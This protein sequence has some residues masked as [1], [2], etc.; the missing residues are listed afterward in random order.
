VH[1]DGKHVT[2]SQL[3]ASLPVRKQPEVK[4]I[5]II[6]KVPKQFRE[7]FVS[8]A[9]PPRDN[10][11]HLEKLRQPPNKYCTVQKHPVDADAL[12]ASLEVVA[13]IFIPIDAERFVPQPRGFGSLRAD[14]PDI[15]TFILQLYAIMVYLI[16]KVRSAEI[17][18]QRDYNE[19]GKPVGPAKPHDVEKNSIAMYWERVPREGQPDKTVQYRLIIHEYGKAG[20]RGLLQELNNLIA[21][22]NKRLTADAK[23]TGL[24]ATRASQPVAVDH[25]S[26]IN[27]AQWTHICQAMNPKSFE[28]N[29]I[30]LWELVMH[31]DSPSN[32]VNCFSSA[33]CCKTAKR[34]GADPAYC[35]PGTYAFD[36]VS[37][38]FIF[39]DG[40]INV[41]RLSPIDF[42]VVSNPL[43]RFC[44][45]SEQPDVRENLA[46]RD[47]FQKKHG[48]ADRE[49]S[50]ALFNRTQSRSAPSA[51]ANDLSALCR[52]IQR[53]D[54][55]LQKEHRLPGS[56][57][58]HELD[59]AYAQARMVKCIDSWIPLLSA[60]NCPTGNCGDA[61][62]KLTEYGEL[63]VQANGS[64][65]M[66]R[67]RAFRNLTRQASHFVADAA[68]LD[69]I[70]TVL[71][72][73]QDILLML[74]SVLHT[75]SYYKMNLNH[76]LLGPAGIGKSFGILILAMLMIPGTYIKATYMTPKAFAVPGK[77]NLMMV[78][79]FEDAAASM[80]EKA[81]KSGTSNDFLNIHKQI[82][83]S[84]EITVPTIIMDPK[85]SADTVKGA[86]CV[87]WISAMNNSSGT[88][89]F[90]VKDRYVVSNS[91]QDNDTS[92]SAAAAMMA[93]TQR[94][95]DPAVQ[96]CVEN[97][98]TVFRR[99]QRVIA[100]IEQAEAAG[101]L[102]PVD[103]AASDYF[104][105]VLDEICSKHGLNLMARKRHVERYRAMCRVMCFKRVDDL[106]HQCPGAVFEGIEYD[107]SH[108]LMAEKYMFTTIQDAVI[109]VLMLGRQWQDK[110][111]TTLIDTI[112]RC[113]YPQNHTAL[114]EW[115]DTVSKVRLRKDGTPCLRPNEQIPE[116]P[117]RPSDMPFVP[118]AGRKAAA[119]AKSLDANHELFLQRSKEYECATESRRDWMYM[120]A[121]IG[122]GGA[123]P[124]MSCSRP[125]G[126]TEDE[127]LDHLAKHI[128]PRMS[129]RFLEAEVKDKLR[130]LMKETIL[131]RRL[132]FT[133]DD[134][135]D[136]YN[137]QMYS[138]EHAKLI[139]SDSCI[140]L[141]F[142]VIRQNHTF[143]SDLLF[144][145]VEDTCSV[146]AAA[147]GDKLTAGEFLLAGEFQKQNGCRFLPR[148]INIE[149][150]EALKERNID[151][152]ALT[153]RIN[154]GYANVN[155]QR[156]IQT[157]QGQVD[158]GVYE[159]SYM[160]RL[161]PSNSRYS[162]MNGSPDKAAALRRAFTIGISH[163]DM[164]AHPSSDP[165]VQ[166]AQFEQLEREM[167]LHDELMVYPDAL[168]KPD[169]DAMRSPPPSPPA[170]G[171]E[172]E[173][174]A[175]L[176]EA[177]AVADR[178]GGAAA[179]AA[180]PRAAIDPHPAMSR[181]WSLEKEMQRM[182]SANKLRPH[183]LQP[184]M[185]HARTRVMHQEQPSLSQAFGSQA[186]VAPDAASVAAPVSP[187]S[188]A[189]DIDMDAAEMEFD[190]VPPLSNLAVHDPA[191]D[192]DEQY[193]DCQ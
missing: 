186:S 116:K 38:C 35:E 180:A 53:E 48:I 140:K 75:W 72:M 27:G 149:S 168:N 40:G 156:L 60:I 155:L 4:H 39:P 88:L 184:F 192:D 51:E 8:V 161:Y 147:S 129:E 157:N 67:M 128:T 133:T 56:R 167:G 141:A 74:W 63:M 189:D 68:E 115:E 120:R 54:A 154:A 118:V 171:K 136:E 96:N 122:Q 112:M 127:I 134:E 64:L 12:D 139:I 59:N 46:A 50:D 145:C 58:T 78:F 113:W 179:A 32:P 70:M 172:A 174:Y 11:P 160:R 176:M 117:V 111:V 1:N 131:V 9:V 181:F 15:A 138:K 107:E 148:K 80:Y 126:P 106:L 164:H 124:A 137:T 163:D 162:I 16:D 110:I 169:D 152:K 103:L 89:D 22:N 42:N 55:Q 3:S 26:N 94:M 25:L 142:P 44:L 183:V 182:K 91:S 81:P 34:L 173:E 30:P 105:S 6:T 57:G 84:R 20:R 79:L 49:K 69:Q 100:E 190:D 14:Q 71:S 175:D 92:E 165:F 130:E 132:Q 83:T 52:R 33:V 104:F 102:R 73:H 47:Q 45:P 7:Q 61:M 178:A 36:V 10:A 114:Q 37:R 85:R 191:D 23:K 143:G 123:V 82:L 109:S 62:Q 99:Q 170:E 28:E 43:T 135:S 153:R 76:L 31:E 29:T 19:D 185:Q 2:Y 24:A 87:T 177:E 17:V 66:P 151:Y 158:K 65:S 146:L 166:H 144:R 41:W 159:K 188:D 150:P 86:G 121:E 77:A 125:S 101:I 18:M 5:D 108:V 90:N 187:A 21:D 13:S 193:D 93:A 119:G 95:D 97:M 98:A